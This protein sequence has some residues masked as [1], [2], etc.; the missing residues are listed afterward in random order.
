MRELNKE[1]IK[2]LR[3]I[4]SNI[5]TGTAKSVIWR[6][7]AVLFWNNVGGTNFKKNTGCGACLGK[8]FVGFKSLIDEYGEKE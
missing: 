4:W 6:E 1:E 3:E 8:V 7:K 5:K 2:E